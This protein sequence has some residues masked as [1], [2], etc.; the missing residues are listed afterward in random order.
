MF[1]SLFALTAAALLLALSGIAQ[2]PAKKTALNKATLEAYIRHLY[3]MDS[4]IVVKISDPIPSDVPGFM[5]MSA[6][7]SMGPQSQ[8][9]KFLISRDGS[10]ILQ[11]AS[12]TSTTTLSNPTWIS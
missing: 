5:E 2:S 6:I 4:R 8:S 10:K 1:K 7:A 9:F 3:V 11:P 12:M